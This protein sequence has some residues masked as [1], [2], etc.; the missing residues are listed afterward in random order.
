MNVTIEELKASYD[1]KFKT[2]FNKIEKIETL[3][4]N[5]HKLT[6][7]INDIAHSIKTLSEQTKKNTKEID[8]L[9]NVDAEKYR[10]IIGYITT[11]IVGAI[12]GYIL[13]QIGIG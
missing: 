9:Q 4:D 3:T 5:I 10:N 13:K 8:A 12:I 1:E 2:L 7:S 11:L 6:L